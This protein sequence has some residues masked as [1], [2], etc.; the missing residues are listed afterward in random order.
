MVLP[1]HRRV[2]GSVV[3]VGTGVDRPPSPC[4]PPDYCMLSAPLARLLAPCGRLCMPSLPRVP[5]QHSAKA[6]L[7]YRCCGLQVHAGFGNAWLNNNFNKKVLEKLQEID[8]A[9]QGTEPLRFWITGAAA[10]A[11]ISLHGG[12]QTV[13]AP[14]LTWVFVGAWP[15]AAGHAGHSLGGALAVLASDE[16]AKAF[17]DSKITCYTW[18][19][20]RAS[21]LSVNCCGLGAACFACCAEEPAM[22]EQLPGSFRSAA[23]SRSLLRAGLMRVPA[24]C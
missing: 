23:A 16:V 3:K 9:Q 6:S 10:A 2:R 5:F 17:P 21:C 7:P 12:S 4:S 18:G 20:P 8:Q 22:P 24:A 13:G 19:A 1:P 11:A 15:V 14:A